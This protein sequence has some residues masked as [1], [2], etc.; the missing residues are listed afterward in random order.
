VVR[1]FFSACGNASRLLPFLATRILRRSS[2]LSPYSLFSF[3]DPTA[4]WCQAIAFVFPAQDNYR[5]ALFFLFPF[6][7]AK[8]KEFVEN[9]SF[10]SFLCLLPSLIGTSSF[11]TMLFSI[12]CGFLPSPPSFL[13]SPALRANFL[14]P[15][16]L[17]PLFSFFGSLIS[18]ARRS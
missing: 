1:G 14:L 15:Y 2:P 10:P 8:E 4:K 9:L 3:S 6:P 13:P 17:R 7:S 5:R 11:G 16:R 18:F 12:T